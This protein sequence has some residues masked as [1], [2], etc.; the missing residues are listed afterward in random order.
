M[1]AVTKSGKPRAKRG[2]GK[3]TPTIYVVVEGIEVVHAKKT[4]TAWIV[5]GEAT[6]GSAAQLALPAA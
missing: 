5:R 6:V 3:S 2:E 4:L 1:T